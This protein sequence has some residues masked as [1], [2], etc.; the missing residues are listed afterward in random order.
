MNND[1][2]HA[3]Y[4][5]A[6]TSEQEDEHQRDDIE[7]WLAQRDL[8]FA[9]VDLYAEQAS[10]ASEAREEFNTLIECIQ[11][12]DID[13]VVVWEVSRIAR[14]GFLA[15]K[16]FDACEDNDVTIHVVNGSVRRVESD[17]H[18]RMVADVIAAVAAEERRQ[19]IRRTKAGL[20]R[21]R[22]EGKWLGQVPKGFVRDEEGYLRPNLAPDYDV[23]ET[24]YLDIVDA[25]E[26]IQNG[27][28]YREAERQTPNVTRQTLMNI[29]KDDKRR[30][31]Y[32]DAEAEDDAVQEALDEVTLDDSRLRADPDE[33]QF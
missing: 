28:S 18:G 27:T 5:R 8:T 6:S 14:R 1:E 23:D 24:G 33:F 3:V 10:G 17:G 13:H 21:A 4:I 22:R 26:A 7:E 32:L 25:L 29:N 2:T 19:L 31:W 11:S 9:D 16:F 15:Q 12:G 20:R 30:C